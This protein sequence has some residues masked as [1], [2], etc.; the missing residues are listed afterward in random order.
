MKTRIMPFSSELAINA[1]STILKDGG[2]IAFPTDTVYGVACDLWNPEAIEK[3]F[4]AKQRGKDKP[5][6]ILIGKVEHIAQIA[7]TTSININTNVL[8]QRFWPGAMT[9]IVPKLA[10][11]PEN[12]SPFDTIGVRMPNH[13]RLLELL[14]QTGPLAVTSANKSGQE[15]PTT[16]EEVF[17]QLGGEIDLILDGGKTD[18]AIPSTVI[19]STADGFNILRQ[20]AITEKEIMALFQ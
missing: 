8:M 12:L 14:S 5:L 1:A 13:P 17:A 19:A 11:I 18:S 10:S 3:L 2:L 4:A 20:G 9:V 16:A 7:E 6:P 15:N